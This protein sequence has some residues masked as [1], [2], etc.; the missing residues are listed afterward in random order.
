[1]EFLQ[2]LFKKLIQGFFLFASPA[3][4][5]ISYSI[6]RNSFLLGILKKTE[7]LENLKYLKESSEEFPEDCLK[8]SLEKLLVM[9]LEIFRISVSNFF[10]GIPGQTFLKQFLS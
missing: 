6:C 10:E 9:L 5:E 3:P 7:I 1:M 4:T 8:E 2:E